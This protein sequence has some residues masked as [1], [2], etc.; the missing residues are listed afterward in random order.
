MT[1]STLV[2]RGS[3][4]GW[5]RGLHSCVGMLAAAGRRAP[6]W[7]HCVACEC[8][9]KTEK[10]KCRLHHQSHPTILHSGFLSFFPSVWK[11]SLGT[12]MGGLCLS[13]RVPGDWSVC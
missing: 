2:A 4:L 12:G 11:M 6:R 10:A 3:N 1:Q 7:L 9:W 8:I 5:G 13:Q